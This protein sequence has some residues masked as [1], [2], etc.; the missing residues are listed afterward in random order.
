[1]SY[2]EG[3]IECIRRE[4]AD[5]Y[6]TGAFSGMPAMLTEVS[7]IE[8]MTDEELVEKAKRDGFHSINPFSD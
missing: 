2:N 7:D 6:G 3:D 1:M 5:Y 4:M 8:N